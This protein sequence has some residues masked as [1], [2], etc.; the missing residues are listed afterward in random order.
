MAPAAV[1][2]AGEGAH[3]HEEA[4][5]LDLAV[6]LDVQGQEERVDLGLVP[7]AVRVHVVQARRSE[8][9]G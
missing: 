3:H 9:L 7:P 2:R 6:A 5:R 8:N 4:D 1:D